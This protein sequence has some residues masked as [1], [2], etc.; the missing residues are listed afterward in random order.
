MTKMLL[1]Y[2]FTGQVVQHWN[3]LHRKVVQSPFMETE[4][5]SERLALVGSAL[6]CGVGLDD[7]QRSQPTP[8]TL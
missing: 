5:G 8:T 7:C 6:S 2:T 1:Y 4:R 3:K